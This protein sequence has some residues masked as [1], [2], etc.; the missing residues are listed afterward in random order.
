MEPSLINKQ[1]ALGNCHSGENIYRHRNR[2][3]VLEKC[4]ETSAPRV[5]STSPDTP[6]SIPARCSL[7][8]FLDIVE[9]TQ[10]LMACQFP[11]P[12]PRLSEVP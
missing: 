10:K 2:E 11:G 9:F 7:S 8:G 12:L 1:K 3:D 5:S 4:T 6:F